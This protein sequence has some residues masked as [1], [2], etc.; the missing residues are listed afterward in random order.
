[1]EAAKLLHELEQAGRIAGRGYLVERRWQSQL[2]GMGSRRARRGFI[3]EA[4]V[5]LPIAKEDFL[6]T[7]E[8]AAA[9][10]NAETACRDLN[11]REPTLRSVE[12]L[13]RQL[14]RAE[15]VA[16]SRIEGL[17]LSHR[18][19][20]RATFAPDHD[21]TAQSVLRNIAALDRA[22]AL[23]SAVDEIRSSDLR[24]VHRELFEGTGDEHRAGVIRGEQ[25]WIGGD[26]SSPR[27]A[28]FVP[29]PREYVGPLLDDLCQFLNRDDVPAVIQ[30]AISHAQ[31]ESIHPFA[32]GNG[33]VGRALILIVL[34]RRGVAH[35]YLPPI[36]LVLAGRADHYIAGLTSWRRDDLSN[37]WLL[38]FADAV[39]RA[40]TRA[41][42][43][44]SAVA[45]LQQR[46]VEQ[47]GQ[48]RRNSTALRAIE[49]LPSH[50]IVNTQTIAELLGVSGEAARQAI[51]RLEEGGVLRQVT[52]GRRNRAWET[53]GLFD[54]LDSFERDLGPSGRTP[55]PTHV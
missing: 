44:A 53:V 27:G 38:L 15:S 48:P 4:Y 16:S 55:V 35:T 17:V 42:E 13:A 34:R 25:N 30:A 11:E 52:I 47:A 20:A 33:R 21:I 22:L 51:L 7:T 36:S 18:R 12:P 14:L 6:M 46:W 23:A 19:L 45:D 1:M 26:G 32:D 5:P 50:P 29:P 39:W 2:A 3:Y 54:L 28:E 31:F 49:R 43:F 41:R 37:D 24:D 8:I 40:A 9:A 10:A